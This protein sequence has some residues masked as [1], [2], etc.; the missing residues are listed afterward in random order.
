MY[1]RQVTVTKTETI[2][3]FPDRGLL[4]KKRVYK[5]VSQAGKP[6]MKL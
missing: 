5:G 6:N 3:S 4:M 2:L 1:I